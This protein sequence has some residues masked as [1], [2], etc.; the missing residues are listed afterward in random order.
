MNVV[1]A[2]AILA[3][4][5][6][7]PGGKSALAMFAGALVSSVNAGEVYTKFA[8]AGLAPEQ[9]FRQL[10]RIGLTVVEASEHHARLAAA[11]QDRSGLSLGDRFCIALGQAMGLPVL[12]ADRIWERM[13]LPVPV[14]LIR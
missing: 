8:K 14:V 6:D 10:T 4:L 7:E 13:A 3:H 9:T 12:T 11:L 1:D 2:S 5:L